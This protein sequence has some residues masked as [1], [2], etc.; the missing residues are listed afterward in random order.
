[1]RACATSALP[2]LLL[3]LLLPPRRLAVRKVDE[4]TAAAVTAWC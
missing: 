3:L 2:L 1:M 4:L